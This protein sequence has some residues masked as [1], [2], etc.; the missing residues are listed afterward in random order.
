MD[1][2]LIF[3]EEY[4]F[5]KS[6]NIATLLGLNSF[7]VPGPGTNN[8]DYVYLLLSEGSSLGPIF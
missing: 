3:I 7:K 1:P 2:S 6:L 8:V 5:I 4:V